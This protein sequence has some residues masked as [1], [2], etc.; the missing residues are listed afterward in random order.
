MGRDRGQGLY[1]THHCITHLTWSSAFSKGQPWGYTRNAL[2]VR[3]R[4]AGEGGQVREG[5]MGKELDR[6][7]PILGAERNEHQGVRCD[8]LDRG[9]H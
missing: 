7:G 2:W 8:T 4:Q 1:R 9:L 3:A 5:Q 6:L